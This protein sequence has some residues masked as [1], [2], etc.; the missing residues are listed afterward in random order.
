MSVTA[1][2]PASMTGYIKNSIGF[3]LNADAPIITARMSIHAL[4]YFTIIYQSLRSR[5]FI[6]ATLSHCAARA[7]ALRASFTM[8]TNTSSSPAG[9]I[10]MPAGIFRRSAS[11]SAP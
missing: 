7:P 9:V 1:V 8:K 4:Q 3:S 2:S 5:P 6:A 10:S 11:A